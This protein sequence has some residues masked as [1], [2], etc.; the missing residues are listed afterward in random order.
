[1]KQFQCLQNVFYKKVPTNRLTFNL[2]RVSS[3]PVPSRFPMASAASFATA[4]IASLAS[5]RRC[6]RIRAPSVTRA[7]ASMMNSNNGGSTGASFG[8]L[9]GAPL[10]GASPGPGPGVRAPPTRSRRPTPGHP[11]NR[12][13]REIRRRAPAARGARRGGGGTR[14]VAAGVAAEARHVARR[15]RTHAREGVGTRTQGR[16]RRG[17][18]HARRGADL[19]ARSRRSELRRLGDDRGTRSTRRRR[20]CRA[21]NERVGRGR[22]RGRQ[23]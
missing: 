17:D 2:F 12:H 5:R 20:R 14:G 4:S 6:A 16:R 15:A 11:T 3:A 21:A 8:P 23:L 13:A 7:M 10:A 9:A 22:G 19:R 18:S 1:M